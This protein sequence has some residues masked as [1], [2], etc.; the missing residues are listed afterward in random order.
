MARRRIVTRCACRRTAGG[1]I[2]GPVRFRPPSL[3]TR[4]AVLRGLGAAALACAAGERA[5]ASGTRWLE[6]R[7]LHT[8]ERFAAAWQPA[9]GFDARSLAS[10]EMLLRDHR[11]GE[12]HEI[13]AALYGQLMTL[14]ATARVDARFEIIS[15]YR[16]PVTNARLH[17]RSGGVASR[18]LHMEGRAI[19]VRLKGIDC[20][21]LAG[22]A[23]ADQ[24]GGVGYYGRDAFVHLDTGRIR[25]WNG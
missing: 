16:S 22:L 17:E 14:A 4:R 12:R 23:R 18:S 15:G 3:L 10:L 2:I 8:G 7:S 13:D 11:N 19:D 5:W 21:R 1:A 24:R 9:T 6:L 20:A 25:S